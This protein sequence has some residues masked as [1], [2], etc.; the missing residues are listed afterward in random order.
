MYVFNHARHIKL[1]LKEQQYSNIK[2]VNNLHCRDNQQQLAQE[3]VLD[4][5]Q[6]RAALQRLSVNSLSG[7]DATTDSSEKS[8]NF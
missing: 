7:S 3:K 2:K 1:S 8:F 4:T 6:K 5:L